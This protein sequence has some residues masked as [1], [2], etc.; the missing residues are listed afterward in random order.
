MDLGAEEDTD[1]VKGLV[2]CYCGLRYEREYGERVVLGAMTLIIGVLTVR[3][4]DVFHVADG[5]S[6]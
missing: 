3:Y 2:W 1:W 4:I 5:V 6:C